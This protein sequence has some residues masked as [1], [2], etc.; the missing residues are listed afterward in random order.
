[1]ETRLKPIQRL[2]FSFGDFTTQE[3][4]PDYLELKQAVQKNNEFDI[5]G[6]EELVFTYGLANNEI[7]LVL[8]IDGNVA[9]SLLVDKEISKEEKYSDNDKTASKQDVWS[10][11][12]NQNCITKIFLSSR[13]VLK[14]K[15]KSGRR[16]AWQ[17]DIGCFE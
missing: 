9:D 10:E 13:Q 17:N 4:R 2:T 16:I 1:M 12:Y 5:R 3:S 14:K 8:S 11:Q 6:N 7:I 15:K